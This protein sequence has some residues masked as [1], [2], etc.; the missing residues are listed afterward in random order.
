M[1]AL[2]LFLYLGEKYLT[3]IKTIM[4]VIMM[5]VMEIAIATGHIILILPLVVVVPVVIV[6]SDPVVIG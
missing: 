1:S 3:E 4:M 5:Q 2:V 6:V